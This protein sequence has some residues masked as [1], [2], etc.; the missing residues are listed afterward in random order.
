MELEKQERSL[1][2]H[3]SPAST[4][5][6]S[7]TKDLADAKPSEAE[8]RRV[9]RKID[10]VLLPLLSGCM[11]LQTSDK[12]LLNSVS[13]LNFQEDVHLTSST[14][15]S[16]LYSLFWI[17]YLIGTFT[18][19]RMIQ[20]CPLGRYVS[21]AV[22]LWGGIAAFHAACHT[23]EAFLAVRFFLGFMEA[24]L[25]SSFILLTGRFYTRDEQ[26]VR[27]SLWYSMYGVAGIVAGA[28]TYSEL[29]HPPSNL[30][31]WQSLYLIYGIVTMAFGLLCLF[32]LPSSPDTTF[33]LKPK[34]RKLAVYHIVEN[35]S[36][37][38][39]TTF[40]WYQVREA[41]LDVRLYLYFLAFA[42]LCIVNGSLY[43]FGNLIIE[44]FHYDK[45]QSALLS[46]TLGGGMVVCVWLGMLGFH[47]L[48][49][50]DV[51]VISSLLV[52]IVG[53]ALM[54]G[55]PAS[56]K[57]GRMTGY[58]LVSFFMLPGP[59]LY[60]CQS[61]TVSGTTKRLVFNV[62]LQVGSSVGNLIGPHPYDHSFRV[63]EAVMMAFLCVCLLL[64]VLISLVHYRM[65]LQKE[66]KA[67]DY[68]ADRATQ[69]AL[70]L[71]DLTDKERHTYRYPY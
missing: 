32:V 49:R 4:P 9:V 54:I 59:V 18:H 36:G 28:A 2:D 44:S 34:E 12:T 19:A 15:L 41:L 31:M 51:V 52:S 17:G 25:P 66:R 71:S 27:T 16:W 30:A 3:F 6:L 68:A 24:A 70:D 35:Q 69:L 50:R 42:S 20:L 57:A 26:F 63:G 39:N 1:E 65:N 56:N 67:L 40:Q 29:V 37:I 43:T 10:W 58:A 53:A 14:Q 60:S 5:D 13:L 45:K 62:G 61:T 8:V 22:V 23:Y 38:H 11:F 46:M 55:L 64:M 21:G 33:F 7:T 47:L 48:K